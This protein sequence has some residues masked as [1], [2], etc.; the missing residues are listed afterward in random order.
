MSDL[1]EAN[2]KPGNKHMQT[3]TETL[4]EMLRYSMF[5]DEAMDVDGTLEILAELKCRDTASPSMT[6]EEAWKVFQSEYSGNESIYLHCAHE[7]NNQAKDR[8]VKQRSIRSIRAS[9][10]V[11]LAAAILLAI[12]FAGTVTSYALGYDLWG[13]IAQWSHETFGFRTSEALDQYEDN[14]VGRGVAR[15]YDD[16]QTALDTH[17]IKEQ[18]APNWLPERFELAELKVVSETGYQL[19]IT[20]MYTNSDQHINVRI[21]L[22]FDEPSADYE[23]DEND[24]IHYELNGISHYIMTNNDQIRAAWINGKL[25]C[26]ISGNLTKDELI[27][28]IDSIY[29]S[30]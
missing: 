27:E 13:A 25:E 6:P 11:A 29:E 20:A 3:S 18:V 7:E 30:R 17:G 15:Q 26:S 24:V 19:N 5:S 12:L 1:S 14:S 16:L 22:L 23:K 28:I 4:E 2:S 10:R 21:A 9:V 8:S